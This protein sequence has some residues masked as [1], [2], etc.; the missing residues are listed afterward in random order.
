MPGRVDALGCALAPG[1]TPRLTA[2]QR[3][4]AVLFL[5]Q[6]RCGARSGAANSLT[7]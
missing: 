6:A 5:R 2:Q 1:C 7:S 4:T 3:R